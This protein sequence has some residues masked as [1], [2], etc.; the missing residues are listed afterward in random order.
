MAGN[1][2]LVK[3]KPDKIFRYLHAFYLELKN[4]SL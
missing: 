4:L 3:V 2:S 1:V